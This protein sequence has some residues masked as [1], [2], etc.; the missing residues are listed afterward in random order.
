[1]FQNNPINQ[2]FLGSTSFAFWIKKIPNT[3]FFVQ[4]ANIPGISINPA[5]TP[6]P[7]VN[8]PYSG[9]HIDYE[10]FVITFKIDEDLQA[11]R[12]I[13]DW[14]RGL[15]FSESTD[16]YKKLANEEIIVKGGSLKSDASLIILDA[17]K[18]PNF[19]LTFNDAFPIA[20]SSIQLQYTPDNIEYLTAD[21][22]FAYTTYDIVRI[23]NG[24]SEQ[25]VNP[26]G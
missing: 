16:E 14:I 20:L 4:R 11:W 15:G 18:R 9:D 2:N 23:K 25:I 5:R 22:T 1:M 24:Q 8:I 6:N 26:G 12:D 21:A 13:Y 3:N 7:L 17:K 10:E 19:D